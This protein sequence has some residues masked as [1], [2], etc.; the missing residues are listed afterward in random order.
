MTSFYSR[1]S[2]KMHGQRISSPEDAVE[3][4]KNHVLKVSQLEW[5]KVVVHQ[6]I[7]SSVMLKNVK[8]SYGT[9]EICYARHLCSCLRKDIVTDK[10]IKIL[11]AHLLYRITT[12]IFVEHFYVV[13]TL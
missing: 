7:R 1:T 3:V 2:K 11:S 4:F 9:A 8:L 5:K 13:Q 12:N 6:N 10:L